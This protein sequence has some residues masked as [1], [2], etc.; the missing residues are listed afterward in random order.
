MLGAG[1]LGIAT[2]VSSSVAVWRSWLGV[3]GYLAAVL[4]SLAVYG[5]SL[6]VGYLGEPTP[7]LPQHRRRARVS[8]TATS[9]ARPS[10]T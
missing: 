9:P 10:V 4:V 8:M 7:A 2:F 3:E 5:A 6:L 1:V